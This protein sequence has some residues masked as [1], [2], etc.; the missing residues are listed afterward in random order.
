MAKDSLKHKVLSGD[1]Q[2]C[3]PSPLTNN[4]ISF[5]QRKLWTLNFTLYD[6]ADSSAQ[7]MMWDESKGARGANE[8]ASSI[9]KW[10]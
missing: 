3:L 9:L 2:R 8:I 1:L 4:C 10:A 7:C 6:A 5:Y